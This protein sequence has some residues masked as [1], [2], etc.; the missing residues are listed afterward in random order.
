MRESLP[1]AFIV[2]PGSGSELEKR[3]LPIPQAKR[4]APATAPIA[5]AIPV[6]SMSSSYQ[7]VCKI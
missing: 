3:A 5:K 2:F 7:Y 1:G 4:A 6:T